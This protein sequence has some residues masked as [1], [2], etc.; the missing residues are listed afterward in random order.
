MSDATELPESDALLALNRSATTA[1]LLSGMIHEINNA[2][3]VISGTLELLEQKPDMPASAAPALE[4]L[5]KQS[6]RAAAVVADVQ[7][8]TRAS[9][10]EFATVNLREIAEHSVNLRTFAIRRAGLAIR[11]DAPPGDYHLPGIRGQL[12]QAVLNLIANAEQALAGTHGSI[13]V[14]LEAADSSVVLRVADDGPGMAMEARERAFGMF[15]STREPWEGAGLGLW[16]ARQI[17]AAHGGTLMYEE[18]PR[19]ASF[20]LRLPRKSN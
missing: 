7:L 8:F 13:V 14:Q 11:L 19:G 16:A 1:R 10:R 12:Q 5:R 4:R 15:A 18:Q 2:L 9:V 17:A 20:A 6:E 3:Q